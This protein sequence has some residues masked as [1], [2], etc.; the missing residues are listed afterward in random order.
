MESF[1]LFDHSKIKKNLKLPLRQNVGLEIFESIDSTN[2]QAK[3]L[4]KKNK[5]VPNNLLNNKL[6]V[7]AADSQLAGR[8][9][10]G[11]SWFSNDPASIAVSFLLQAKNEIEQLPQITAAAALAVKDCF[12]FF[13]LKVEIKWPND[14][15]INNK[16]ICGILSELIFDLEKNAYLIIGCGVNLN[17]EEFSSEIEELAT[18]YY[19]E[20]NEKIDKN[21][22]LAKLIEKMNSYLFKYLNESREKIISDWKSELN[23]VGRKI[24]FDYK[25]KSYT[26]IIED[27]LESGELLM[28]FENGQQK[29]L[30]SLNTS[31]NYQSLQ[32]YNNDYNREG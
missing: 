13:N 6:I 1:N 11:H 20:R 7:L 24:D 5:A 17:N 32:I 8:G 28:T 19:L 21:L 4:V 3:K 23:L 16:K 22:F 15:L 26:G 27:V 2:T 30:Q 18:S 29:K 9:R 12:D 31:L 14:I 10:R 25:N